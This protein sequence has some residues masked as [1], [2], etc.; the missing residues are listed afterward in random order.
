MIETLNLLPVV[1]Q[2][3]M[4]YFDLTPVPLAFRGYGEYA[5]VQAAGEGWVWLNI[6]TNV[7]MA[8]LS[9]ERGDS[10]PVGRLTWETKVK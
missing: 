3:R 4:Y 2:Q 8:I 1:L 6:I 9:S 10:F 7:T 5:V